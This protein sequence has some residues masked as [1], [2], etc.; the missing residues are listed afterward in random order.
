[1]ALDVAKQKLSVLLVERLP[2]PLKV[3]VKAFDPVTLQ[4]AMK[5]VLKLEKLVARANFT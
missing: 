2:K 5:R 4:D 3:L 1:M